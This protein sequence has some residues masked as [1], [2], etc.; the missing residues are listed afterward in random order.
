MKWSTDA[1]LSAAAIIVAA[2]TYIGT[3]R[4]EMRIRRAE[5]VRAYTTEFYADPGVTALFM[6]ID[7]DRLGNGHLAGSSRELSLIRLLD[8]FNAMGH[9]WKRGV[10]KLDD[11]FP[12]TL[13]YAALR[14]WENE[15]V[16]K[17]LLQIKKWDEE[18]YAPGSGFRYFE[19]FAIEIAF[20]CRRIPTNAH[21]AD[22]VLSTPMRRT[23][24]LVL[25]TRF[26]ILRRWRKMM[27]RIKVSVPLTRSQDI[28]SARDIH[29]EERGHTG[30]CSDSVE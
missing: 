10:L 2:L 27:W 24:G 15:A 18:R 25:F 20:L 22:L 8:Y 6:D 30:N 9:N 28:P 3:K 14:T 13:A 16:R 26:P 23:A 17:Y 5:L 11:I 1:A 4:R 29:R 19:Q 21:V 7:Y 12:T